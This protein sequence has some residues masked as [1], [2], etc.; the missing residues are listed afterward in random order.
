MS[1]RHE[2]IDFELLTTCM[3]NERNQT[4]RSFQ[5]WSSSNKSKAQVAEFV[6]VQASY[7]LAVLARLGADI[8]PES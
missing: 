7:F 8:S 1:A 2:G 4:I 5:A 6:R 3:L